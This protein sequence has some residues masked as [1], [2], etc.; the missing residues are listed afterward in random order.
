MSV[1]ETTP[2]RL[3]LRSGGTLLTL[4]KSAGKVTLGLRLWLWQRK[5]REVPL[6]QITDI[7]VASAVDRAS[8][9]EINSNLVM[10]RD[11]QVW[12]LP[13]KD[14]AEAEQN[15]IAVREFLGLPH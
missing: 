7:V 4:D 6:Q 8:S 12:R 10:M 3:V 14:K 11:G 2:A 5:P 13:A 15:A 9:V 1:V